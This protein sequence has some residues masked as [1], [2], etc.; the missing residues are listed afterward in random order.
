[1]ASKAQ[2]SMLCFYLTAS[3]E[4]MFNTSKAIHMSAQQR[5]LVEHLWGRGGDIAKINKVMVS[6]EN[7]LKIYF[8]AWPHVLMETINSRYIMFWVGG[9]G[10]AEHWLDMLLQVIQQS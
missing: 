3:Q 4:K 8:L 2:M 1:M 7:P 6:F 5:K 10:L 9:G